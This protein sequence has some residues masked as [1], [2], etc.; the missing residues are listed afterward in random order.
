MRRQRPRFAGPRRVRSLRQ[1]ACS[2]SG[3][4]SAH[5]ARGFSLIECTLACAIAA[6]GVLSLLQVF[7]LAAAANAGARDMALATVLAAQKLEELRAVD[8]A[9]ID[10][11]EDRLDVR[12][13]AAGDG[14][15]AFYRRRW[16]VAPLASDPDN[17]I[18]VAVTV[19]RTAARGEVR[20]VV[21]R[22]RGLW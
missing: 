12:G 7:A 15:P 4:A 16:D 6:A 1:P 17:S 9:A 5:S 19:T 11:G 8:A 14:Q 10:G 13:A 20:L 3:V 18:L 22:A 2:T 21:V